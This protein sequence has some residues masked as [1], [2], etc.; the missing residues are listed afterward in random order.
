MSD[1]TKTKAELLEVRKHAGMMV[2]TPVQAAMIAADEAA[3]AAQMR[4]FPLDALPEPLMH[5]VG[6][7]PIAALNGA[8]Q[9]RADV[10]V[11][12]VNAPLS[13][14]PAEP[15]SL[16]VEAQEAPDAGPRERFDIVR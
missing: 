1:K 11:N 4:W 6:R 2:P 15:P 16:E 5:G 3:K 7:M 14:D 8:F 13:E 10:P 9:G 12:Y